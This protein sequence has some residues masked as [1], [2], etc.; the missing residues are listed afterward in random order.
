MWHYHTHSNIVDW[1][2]HLY[3]CIPYL[4]WW[5]CG[6][7]DPGYSPQ[8]SHRPRL[9]AKLGT[10]PPLFRLLFREIHSKPHIHQQRAEKTGGKNLTRYSG[11][12][13]VKTHMYRCW[14]Y[15][16]KFGVDVLMRVMVLHL[17]L[18]RKLQF[19]W[20]II[21]VTD[22]T[23]LSRQLSFSPLTFVAYIWCLWKWISTCMQLLSLRW[24]CAAVSSKSNAYINA[25]INTYSN[26]YQCQTHINK[27]AKHWH[28]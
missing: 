4:P 6:V 18:R 22:L 9:G 25:Y 19:D 7:I 23:W 3:T 5:T 11:G 13:S 8:T 17:S 12:N 24:P 16:V 28:F 27:S 26:T 1:P 14:C 2:C 15:S 10:W 21:S 20:L